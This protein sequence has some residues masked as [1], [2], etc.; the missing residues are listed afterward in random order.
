MEDDLERGPALS[1]D[2]PPRPRSLPPPRP[3]PLIRAIRE[4]RRLAEAAEDRNL[5]FILS[6]CE[7]EA[8]IAKACAAADEPDPEAAN[9]R[10]A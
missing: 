8:R 3:D 1:S 9:L 7:H 10:G 6:L 2:A 4:A 5:A